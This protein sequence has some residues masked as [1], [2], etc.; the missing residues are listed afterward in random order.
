LALSNLR[1]AGLLLREEGD[2]AARDDPDDLDSHPLVREHFGAQL[3]AENPEAWKEAHSRLFE[4]FRSKAT[5][6][7]DTF[8][9]MTPLYTAVAHGCQAG[10]YEEA[11]GDV[12]GRR[13]LR[14]EE[15]FSTRKL[16][17]FGSEL[18]AV[19]SFFD[20][21]WRHP[22]AELP[23]SDRSFLLNEAG[24]DLRALGRL[25]EA[26]EPLD[27]GLA[28][29][30]KRSDWKNA[31]I[32]AG[33]LSELHLTIGTVARAV[34]YGRESVELADRSGDWECRM[35]FRTT[36]ADAYHQSGRVSEAEALFVEAEKMQKEDQPEYPFLYS[37][38]GFRYCDLLLGQGKIEE[39]LRRAKHGLTIAERNH[40]LLAIALDH[41]SLGRAHLLWA[42]KE[43]RADFGKAQ[44]ELDQAVEGLRRTGRQDCLPRGLLARAELYRVKGDFDRA[45]RDLDEASLIAARGGMGLFEAD[46]RLESA[47][48][49]LAAGDKASARPHLDAARALIARTGYHRRDADLRILADEF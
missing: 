41:L 5:D 29:D 49:A 47:R 39:V 27:A 3:K 22:V 19:A 16:G 33:N 20:P 12:Y 28:A 44:K 17:A 25:K 6:L 18:A 24:F 14:G 45:R 36:L 10:R 7:P 9:E 48:L 26:I 31:A 37:V 43:G 2:D 15:F 42:K 13:I 21:P 40:W 46:C 1:D 34:E 35:A 38:R 23:E 11:F 4:Y 30:R 32:S 8:E